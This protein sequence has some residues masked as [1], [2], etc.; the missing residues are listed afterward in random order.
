MLATSTLGVHTAST[1]DYPEQA[2]PHTGPHP[3]PDDFFTPPTTRG[4]EWPDNPQLRRAVDW[5]RSFMS[6]A[7]WEERRLA[8]AQRLYDAAL[9]R[10][11][12]IAGKGRFFAETD[13]FGWYLFLAEAFLDHIWNYEP[14]YGSRVVPLFEAIGR[15]LA[16]LLDIND[17]KERVR[18]IVGSERAQP[19]GGLFEL[20]VAAAYCRAGGEVSFLPERPGVTK[21]HDMDVVIERTTWAVECK[22][23][24]VGEFGD[25]ERSRIREL[26]GPLG[27]VFAQFGS[28]VFA[29]IQF[30]VPIADVPEDYLRNLCLR[31]KRGGERKI[32]WNDHV[33]HGV[34]KP[35]NLRPLRRVLKKDM[36]LAGSTR[37][38]QL[39]TGGYHRNAAYNSI[40]SVKYAAN[41]RYIEDC[42]VAVLL[43]W[44]TLAPASIN[45]KARDIHRKLV[46]ACGQLPTDR[47]GVVHVGFEAVEGDR[48]EKARYEKIIDTARNFDPRGKPLEYVYCHYFVP[49]SPPDGAWAFDETTQWA[50][51]AHTR[52]RPLDKV[53]LILEPKAQDREGLTGRP[54]VFGRADGMSCSN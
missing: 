48:V 34:M 26:W 3:F 27:T 29:D 31:F 43:R 17:I 4:E 44:E 24:E 51:I 23:M 19:N 36:V 53:F 25:Q 40:L 32:S 20:L 41:P 39:L 49:E 38:T 9:Q 28:S 14:V 46:E 8:A 11:S 21:T 47:P 18:R 10:P 22:R 37:L 16:L 54:N 13:T 33:S 5:F 52:P 42:D 7:E 15:D 50:A 45:A 30:I 2:M 12:A 35:L 6:V 1:K